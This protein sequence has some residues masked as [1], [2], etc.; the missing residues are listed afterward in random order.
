[1][2]ESKDPKTSVPNGIIKIILYACETRKKLM[3]SDVCVCDLVEK[4]IS[5][6]YILIYATYVYPLHCA[7]LQ[8]SLPFHTIF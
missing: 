5:T 4:A 1:M 3:L 2:A 7:P 8:K 6:N